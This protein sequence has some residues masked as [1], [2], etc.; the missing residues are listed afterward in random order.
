MAERYKDESSRPAINR[1]L[2]CRRTQ[3][4]F[5]RDG[6]TEDINQASTFPDQMEAVRACIEHDLSDIDLVL[7]APGGRTDLFCTLLR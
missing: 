4:Y 7:R 1:L 3:R 6:W 5:K 2:R